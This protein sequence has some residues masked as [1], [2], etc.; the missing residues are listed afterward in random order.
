MADI[1]KFRGHYVTNEEFTDTSAFPTDLNNGDVVVGVWQS[2]DN[3]TRLSKVFTYAIVNGVGTWETD[4]SEPVAIYST[5]PDFVPLESRLLN[6]YEPYGMGLHSIL[7]AFVDVSSIPNWLSGKAGNCDVPADEL[8]FHSAFNGVKVDLEDLPDSIGML[9]VYIRSGEQLVGVGSATFI[10]SWRVMWYKIATV[11]GAP[12]AIVTDM[13]TI[14]RTGELIMRGNT[15]GYTLTVWDKDEVA[16][17]IPGDY[18]E[19][20]TTYSLAAFPDLDWMYLILADQNGDTVYKM[21]NYLHPSY[22][23]LE[24]AW[25]QYESHVELVLQGQ[26]DVIDSRIAPSI[27]S[28][29]WKR[30]LGVNF[31]IDGG[32]ANTLDFTQTLDGGTANG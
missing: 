1:A 21:T 14:L 29:N 7:Y 25:A 3:T 31:N 28:A 19:P 10:G 9:P 11:Q 30:L 32:Y 13:E 6:V 24:D 16:N 23:A 17:E 15:T 4:E 2:E 26:N 12:P 5:N 27:D 18:D 22:V 8:E 20:L